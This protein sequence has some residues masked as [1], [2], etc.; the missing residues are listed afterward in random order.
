MKPHTVS[1]H[2]IHSVSQRSTQLCH[3]NAPQ[4]VQNTHTQYDRSACDQQKSETK[5]ASHTDPNAHGN[6]ASELDRGGGG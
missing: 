3:N 6:T 1:Q 4:Y 2:S 5:A